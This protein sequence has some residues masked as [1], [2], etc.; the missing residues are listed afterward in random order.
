MSLTTSLPEYTS[1]LPLSI[2]FLISLNFHTPVNSQITPLISFLVQH[3]IH[4][5]LTKTK[6]HPQQ[7]ATEHFW[8]VLQTCSAFPQHYIF[9]LPWFLVNDQR[10][11]QI[12]PYVFIS[13]YSSLHG[14]CRAYHQERQI[15]SIQPLVTVILSWWPRCVQVGRILI[16]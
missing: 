6:I 16:W 10:D 4:S 5:L 8:T 9:F 3:S 13:I 15:V 12:L 2:F 7:S 1:H 14:T 11:A